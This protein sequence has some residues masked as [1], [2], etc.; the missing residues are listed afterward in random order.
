MKM[1]TH[2]DTHLQSVRYLRKEAAKLTKQI[3]D[4]KEQLGYVVTAEFEGKI[5]RML[6]NVDMI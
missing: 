5:N 6:S 2:V 3:N 1:K 4:L